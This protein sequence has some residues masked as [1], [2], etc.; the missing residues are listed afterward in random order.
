R[1]IDR[2][3]ALEV[4]GEIPRA[5]YES[6]VRHRSIAAN[7]EHYLGRVAGVPGRVEAQRDLAHNVFEIAG[8]RK[9]DAFGAHAR[10]VGSASTLRAA[11]CLRRGCRRLG[12]RHVRCGR[13]WRRFLA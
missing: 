2:A 12:G 1:L 4:E 13:R 8:I 6:E 9:L 3:L 10:D 5:R 7:E 11:A